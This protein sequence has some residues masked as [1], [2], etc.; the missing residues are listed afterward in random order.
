M[1]AFAGDL[2][3]A[4]DLYFHQDPCLYYSVFFGDQKAVSFFFLFFFFFFFFLVHMKVTDG[5]SLAETS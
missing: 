2:P 3:V 1:R 5:D 4:D